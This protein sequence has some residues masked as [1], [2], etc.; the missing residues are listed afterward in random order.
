MRTFEAALKESAHF[1]CP[2][3]MKTSPSPSALAWLKL[4]R[5]RLTKRLRRNSTQKRMKK[6][7]NS[8]APSLLCLTGAVHCPVISMHA[9][10]CVEEVEEEEAKGKGK[11][12]NHECQ[13]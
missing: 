10:L 2:A 13:C 12:G 8:A 5:T 9:Y 7:K 1:F 3:V 6:M 4:S 11:K